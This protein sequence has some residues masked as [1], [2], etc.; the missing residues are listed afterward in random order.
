MPRRRSLRKDSGDMNKFRWS[1]DRYVG[2]SI[3]TEWYQTVPFFFTRDRC[4]LWLTGQY[5]G[6]SAF[7]ICNGPSLVSGKYDLSLLKYP[8]VMTYGMN[9]GPRT[10][11]PNF[12]SCVDDPVRFIK[13]IWLDPRITKFVPHAHAEK[14][15]FDNETW[16]EMKTQD[17]Q[18]LLVGDCP[19]VIYFHR[20]EKFMPDRFLFEDTINWGD[21]SDVGPP[22]MKGGRS[23]MLPCLKILFLLGFRRVYLLGADFTM[24][25]DYAYHFD[26]QR[27][28]GAVNCNTNTY[29]KMRQIY[30]P[31]LK[32]YFDAEGF[33]IYNCNPNSAIDTFP[34]ASY[35]DAIADC[36]MD[37]GD[38]ENE[39]TWGMYSKPSEKL[40]WK[41]N[42]DDSKKPHLQTI[43]G[44][45]SPVHTGIVS[46]P[47]P[48][49]QKPSEAQA[50]IPQAVMPI[51]LARPVSGP[52]TP[53]IEPETEQLPDGTQIV[54]ISA[55]NLVP[56]D[57]T[58]ELVQELKP[59][60]VPSSTPREVAQDLNSR[61]MAELSSL[62]L[63]QP[64]VKS[65]TQTGTRSSVRD[66]LVQ[67]EQQLQQGDESRQIS[68]AKPIMQDSVTPPIAN[69]KP[70]NC[71]PKVIVQPQSNLQVPEGIVRQK[72]CGLTSQIPKIPSPPE[73]IMIED[74]G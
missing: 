1:R 22:G 64:L 55:D 47:S 25:K 34:F 33:E 62:G 46:T 3:S 37:L 74:D 24:T 61:L 17:G 9:N 5:R 48:V 50:Q 10:V 56:V 15:I 63:K 43:G 13:S 53:I 58:D 28:E 51:S 68:S 12:W 70:V 27:H 45:N 20:N 11:R 57:Q 35:E 21:H 60:E 40:K 36:T 66:G 16:T 8:G 59:A 23:V 2:H 31:Q 4:P 41:N 42:V 7:L 39:R 49:E 32:P 69:T 26:E 73:G 30:F 6:R 71:P 14:K 54:R 44:H 29:D 65:P 38:I 72:P 67:F 52:S 18:P 19:N